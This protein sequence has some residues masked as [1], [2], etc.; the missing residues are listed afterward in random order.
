LDPRVRGS[1]RAFALGEIEQVLAGAL[2]LV[3]P[4]MWVN[5]YWK[6]RR[7][8]TKLWQYRVIAQ[9]GIP[10]A[11]TVVTNDA[12]AAQQWSESKREVIYKTLHSPLLADRDEQGE[13]QFVFSSRLRPTD[14]KDEAAI[15]LAP[16][17][18]QVMV[19]ASYEVRVTTIGR[20]HIA[21]RIDHPPWEEGQAVDWRAYP[22]ALSHSQY[23]LPPYVES[24]LNRL[25]DAL[26]I[27]FGASDWL[28]EQNGRHTLLEVNPHGA[29]LWLENEVEN[30]G[31]T[32]TICNQLVAWVKHQSPSAGI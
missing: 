32:T 31:I 5:A 18:F 22:R 13:R 6:A 28:V 12:A 23:S 2:D 21:V 1:Q 30:L 19:E 25:M 7:A 15:G 27:E 24:Q 10:F 26:G 4:G 29:W 3:E 17:Q 14:L 8:A 11:D 16:C 20:S 9:L